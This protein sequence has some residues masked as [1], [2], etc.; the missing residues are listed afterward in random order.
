MASTT[1]LEY[2]ST[3][4]GEGGG[5]IQHW[6]EFRAFDFKDQDSATATFSIAL[7]I[8]SDALQ[9]SYKSSYEAASLGAVGGAAK[10][11]ADTF[12]TT[13][14]ASGG[15]PGQMGKQGGVEGLKNVMAAQAA[16][17]TSEAGTVTLLKG[18]EKAAGLGLGDTKTLMEQQTGSVMNPYMVA[19]YKG[20][21]DMRE[22]KFSFKMLPQSEEESKTCAK[23]VNEFK[24]AML[25][26]HRGGDNVTAPSMLFGYPNQFLIDYFINGEKLKHSADNPNPMFNIGKSVL[27]ACD[28]NYT[29]QDVPLFFDDRQFPVSIDMALS[30]MEIGVMYREKID[31]GF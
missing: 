21:T 11:A 25:P 14:A 8:P 12:M 24:K 28:L 13:P 5:A 30:F 9:T 20:P 2:P 7:Y 6:I 4:G 26:S 27:T 29:T 15:S 23:I 18:A 3:I 1:Y 19:A 16:A 10:K 22:H 17:T 31:Q